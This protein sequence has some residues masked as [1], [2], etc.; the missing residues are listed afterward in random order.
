VYFETTLSASNVA[1]GSYH[2]VLRV[3]NPLLDYTESSLRPLVQN[4][5]LPYLTPWPVSFANTTQGNDGWLDL[6]TMTVN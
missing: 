3:R 5:W 1:A 2:L 4:D 6:G